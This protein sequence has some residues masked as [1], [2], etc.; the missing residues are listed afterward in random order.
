MK[1]STDKSD[2]HEELT[3]QII[4]AAMNVSNALG[5]GFFER[6]YE[7]ALALE[8]RS[9]GLQVAQQTPL[10]VTYRDETVGEYVADLIAD[11]T[12]LV[13]TKATTEDHPTS[14]AQ[15]LNYLK[16]TGLPVGL[17]FNFGRP[18]VSYRGLAFDPDTRARKPGLG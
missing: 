3:G 8:L 6:V 10:Q 9:M 4:K 2:P 15:T 7:N 12:V 16:A 11:H 5:C 18:R 1:E 14:V 13:E 17:L